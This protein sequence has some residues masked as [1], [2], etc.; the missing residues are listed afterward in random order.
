M[1][2]SDAATESL[3]KHQGDLDL[4]GIVDL[5]IVVAESLAK[6][7]GDLDLSRLAELAQVS[8][9]T[10]EALSSK[11]GTICGQ[12]PAEWVAEILHCD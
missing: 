4:S 12:Y 11:Q 6:H 7:N 2:L 10:G 8:D 9:A 1:E 5:S 3:S